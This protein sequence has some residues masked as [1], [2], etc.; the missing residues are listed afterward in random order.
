MSNFE[1]E[2][3][4]GE[5]TQPAQACMGFYSRVTNTVY[6]IIIINNIYRALYK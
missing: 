6:I 5:S 1:F 3:I 2:R 4:G